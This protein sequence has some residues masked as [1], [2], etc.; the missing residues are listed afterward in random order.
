MKAPKGMSP[1]LLYW[2][3]KSE[4]NVGGMAIEV[5]YSHQYSLR[6]AV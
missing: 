3:T 6:G 1:I 4:A 2:P 5:E